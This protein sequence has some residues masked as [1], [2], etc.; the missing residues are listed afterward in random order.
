MDNYSP[1]LELCSINLYI[2]L[3]SQHHPGPAVPGIWAHFLILQRDRKAKAVSWRLI[4][5]KLNRLDLD[6]NAGLTAG[7]VA[8]HEIL[9]GSTTVEEA[10]E[11]VTEL[12]SH[13]RKRI[14]QMVEDILS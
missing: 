4:Q 3:Y 1:P 13:I 14:F 6:F 12:M 9:E 7:I 2:A 11:K 5:M 8:C 10:Q